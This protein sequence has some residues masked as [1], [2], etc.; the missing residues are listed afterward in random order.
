MSV[1]DENRAGHDT[2]PGANGE[3]PPAA[4]GGSR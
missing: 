4:Q 1:N 3:A 2:E